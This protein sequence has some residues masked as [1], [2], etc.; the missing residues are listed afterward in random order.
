MKFSFII[1]LTGL[2]AL[3]LALFSGCSS[4]NLARA[5]SAG[6]KAVQAATI[7]DSYVESMVSEYIVQLD[8]AS[9]V[10][11]PADPYTLRLNRIV[12]P[13]AGSGFNFKVY[14]TPQVNAFAVADGSI[15]VYSGLMDLMTDDEVLGVI[16][17]E[18]GHVMNKDTKDA[19]RHALAVSAVRD[20]ISATGGVVG[21][22][23]DS[24]LGDLT[25]ALSSSQYSQKQELEADDYGYTFLVNHGINPWVLALAFEKLERLNG[26]S[27]SGVQQMFSSHPDTANRI[28]RVE[29]KA[30][31]D[32][33]VNPQQGG[34]LSI[35]SGT[36]KS[37]HTGSASPD[38]TF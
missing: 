7:S 34:S 16:G 26:S 35:G 2:T 23:S 33:Y 14:L 9:D 5:S 24:G 3:P 18:I 15:R 32:G 21:A 17:H 10:A 36:G 11:G 13:L 4:L 38:W 1:R 37:S 6:I 27:G 19:F 12:A 20:G 22:L 28:A 30:T 31:K 8:A 29:K 25:E